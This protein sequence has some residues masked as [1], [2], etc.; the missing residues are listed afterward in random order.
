VAWLLGLAQHR[1]GHS[2][3][4]RHPVVRTVI[5]RHT[6]TET[7]EGARQGYRAEDTEITAKPRAND[8]KFHQT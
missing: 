6:V 1:R 5:A 8:S 7:L 4:R 2:T 3:V